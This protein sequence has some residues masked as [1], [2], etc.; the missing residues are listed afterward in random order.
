MRIL[1]DMGD[2][3]WS[4]F[5]DTTASRTISGSSDDKKN[6]TSRRISVE[7]TTLNFVFESAAGVAIDALLQTET[8]ATLFKGVQELI[9]RFEIHEFERAGIRFVVLSAIKKGV[10]IPKE[11]FNRLFDQQLIGCINSKF[12]TIDDV[13]LSVDGEG[14]DKLKYH[15]RLGPYTDEDLKKQQFTKH[16]ASLVEESG[17]KRNVIFDLDL[18]EQKFALTVKPSKWALGPIEKSQKLVTELEKLFSE[19]F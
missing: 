19:R 2:E 8:V 3:Y 4:E 14:P 7:P 11:K 12:G 18:Y 6:G 13:G 1:N 10:P 15:C 9:E 17:I 5:Q 16:V